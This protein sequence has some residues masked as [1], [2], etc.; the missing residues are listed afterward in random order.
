MK[1]DLGQKWLD[2][3]LVY[4]N[5]ALVDSAF[6][7]AV[8]QYCSLYP[9]SQNS[10]IWYDPHINNNRA[11]SD[12]LFPVLFSKEQYREGPAGKDHNFSQSRERFVQSKW[13]LGK[14]AEANSMAKNGSAFD[15]QELIIDD[16]LIYTKSQNFKDVRN[17]SVIVA[18]GGPSVSGSPWE[19]LDFDTT[20]S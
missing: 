3:V 17:K 8:A 11:P 20:W 9:E 18:C 12:P 4:Q 5:G 1:L 13:G 14:I 19:K 15:S 6:E 10:T 2:C 16:E 7:Q